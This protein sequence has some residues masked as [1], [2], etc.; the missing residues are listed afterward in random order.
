MKEFHLKNLICDYIIK[1]IYICNAC[2]IK[3]IKS[4]YT[5]LCHLK[6]DKHKKN[7]HYTTHSCLNCNSCFVYDGKESEYKKNFETHMENCEENIMDQINVDIPE[8][9]INEIQSLKND[10][11]IK[12]DL[13]EKFQQEIIILKKIIEKSDENKG[14]KKLIEILEKE[15]LELREQL[16]ESRCEN[17][18]LNDKIQQVLFDSN[19]EVKQ[20][21]L[22]SKK[23]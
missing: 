15:N 12:D 14:D 2:G 1:M 10:I 23:K 11:F 21:L 19:K 22:G 13:I 4:K 3:P 6:T 7:A 18:L 9:T 20:I 8:Q 17:K 5:W 16:K